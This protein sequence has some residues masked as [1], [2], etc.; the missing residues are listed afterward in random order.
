MKRWLL[1]TGALLVVTTAAVAAWGFVH[2]RHFAR[3]AYPPEVGT[4]FVTV[5]TGASFREVAELLAE[6]GVVSDPEAFRLMA[7]VRNATR[8]IQAGEYEIRTPVAPPDLLDLLVRGAVRLHSL[9]VPEGY[10]VRQIAAVVEEAGIGTRGAFIEMATTPEVPALYGVEAGTMEGY[11][12]PDTYRYSRGTTRDDLLAMMVRRFMDV[13]DESFRWRAREAGLT[14]HE[15][16][17]LASIVEKE[18]GVGSER[19]RIASVFLNRLYRGMRLQADPTVIYGIP[20]F[21]GN[22]TRRDLRTPTP[23]NTYVID[24][25]PP[26]PICS[27]GEDS[28]RAVL[29]P[30]ETG[31]LYFVSQN[32]GTHKFS[33]T[34]SEH[35]RAVREFQIRRRRR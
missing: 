18:T 9:T 10:A 29:W 32:D 31:Y 20:D 25:L 15:V 27:P 33:R 11:L 16:V 23:Y 21:N 5:P 30:E 28:L 13:F 26:G 7:R 17:T 35:L 24:G 3:Q 4:V 12:F 22:I 8:Q 6:A 2:Y 19:P 14:V 34:Y 1:A